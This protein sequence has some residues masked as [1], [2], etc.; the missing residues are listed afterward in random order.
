MK[1]RK[2]TT[3]KSGGRGYANLADVKIV[4][5]E[6]VIPKPLTKMVRGF[7]VVYAAETNMERAIPDF[8]DGLKPVGRKLLYAANS[9]CK[10]SKTKA[11]RVL[12]QVIGL[13]HPHGESGAYSALVTSVNNATPE[14]IGSGNWGTPIDSAAAPRYTEVVMSKFGRSFFLP[15]YMASEVTPFV[16]N[17][18]RSTTE[19]LVL[20]AL[21][22]NVLFN[23]AMG[24]GVGIRTSLPS[25]T[26]PSVLALMVRLLE[27]DKLTAKDYAKGLEF[28]EPWGS[29]PTTD[30]KTRSSIAELMSKTSGTVSFDSD[31]TIEQDAKTIIVKSFA[32]GVS[33]EN[34]VRKLRLLP[35][36]Q[37][38]YPSA[39]ISYVV[40]AKKTINFAEF[41]K[42]VEKIT[43]ATR[44]AQHYS[45]LVTERL[46]IGGSDT[47]EYEVKFHELT[48]PQLMAKWLHWRIGLE[49]ASLQYRI[50]LIRRDIERTKLLIFACDHLDVIF[51]AL[52]TSDPDAFLIKHLK[53]TKEQANAILEL[54]VRQ[55]SKLDHDKLKEVLREQKETLSVLSEKVKKPKAEVLEFLRSSVSRFKLIN[56]PM[57]QRHW[58]LA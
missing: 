20:P 44:G 8:R 14:F 12:G 19:P 38:V 51:K 9:I 10:E 7:M 3:K 16:P 39:G 42:L 46:P 49:K 29:A 41:D 21:L 37:S 40:K 27:G 11:A 2:P 34:T 52:R 47:G 54:K 18:D 1:K 50:K 4:A 23:G 6:N 5:D 56:A 32:P 26:P 43:K 30:K 13:Y 55:L 24:V 17:Y 48:I 45:I 58:L 33:I 28:Y 31:I 25:F 57:G 35:E 36:V 53:L 15:S 22:P